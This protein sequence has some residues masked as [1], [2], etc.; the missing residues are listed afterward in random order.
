MQVGTCITEAYGKQC[1]ICEPWLECAS[2]L[3]KLNVRCGQASSCSL[4]I[5]NVY[6]SYVTPILYRRLNFHSLV[7]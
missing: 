3:I 5:G 2:T 4:A 1:A 6:K 7:C